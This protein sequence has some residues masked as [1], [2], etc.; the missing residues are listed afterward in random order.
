MEIAKTG[1]VFT[2][3][4]RNSAPEYR[5]LNVTAGDRVCAH[6]AA[7]ETLHTRITVALV[8][9]F[10][11][12]AYAIEPVIPP[13][14]CS[15]TYPHIR[16][17]FTKPLGKTSH[18]NKRSTFN[19]N[20]LQTS[21]YPRP[22]TSSFA[23][24]T[25]RLRRVMGP[26][27]NM[28]RPKVNNTMRNHK[29]R[30]LVQPQAGRSEELMLAKPL[31]LV[32]AQMLTW[33]GSLPLLRRMEHKHPSNST[34]AVTLSSHR[35]N[36]SKAINNPQSLLF[37]TVSSPPMD[38]HHNQAPNLAHPRLPMVSRHMVAVPQ[39]TN[40]RVLHIPLSQQALLV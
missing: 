20:R 17:E 6:P 40:L 5:G 2:P 37:P 21:L 33:A 19:C 28:I 30:R 10:P 31:T 18:H 27:V 8:D 9:C 4:R 39:V 15:A 13:L 38:M 35:Y 25:W 32:P 34:E 29:S 11:Y 3:T 1:L 7:I 16:D 36:N 23:F 22:R 24:F 12:V 14:V 26:K